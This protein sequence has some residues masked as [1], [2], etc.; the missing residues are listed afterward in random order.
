MGPQFNGPTQLTVVDGVATSVGVSLVTSGDLNVQ[1]LTAT[2][3]AKTGILSASGDNVTGSG[4]QS[5]LITGTVQQ[6]NAALATLTDTT[7]QADTVNITASDSSGNVTNTSIGVTPTSTPP[8][9]GISDALFYAILSMDAYN[10]QTDGKLS[11]GDPGGAGTSLGGATFRNFLQD[12]GSGGFFGVTWIYG[13]QTVIAYRGSTNPLNIITALTVAAGS[14]DAADEQAALQLYEDDK[15]G[16]LSFNPNIILTGH[17]LGGALAGWVAGNTGASSFDYDTTGYSVALQ[18]EYTDEYQA[19]KAGLGLLPTPPNFKTQQG[20]NLVGDVAANTRS[21]H[22]VSTPV[23][24]YAGTQDHLTLQ[25][26][27]TRHS[28]A[29]LVIYMY[30]AGDGI[31]NS[32]GS[33]IGPNLFS[34][35][36]NNAVAAAIGISASDIMDNEI[37]YSALQSGGTPF[38][39]T[40]IASLFH[41]ADALGEFY[42][43]FNVDDTLDDSVIQNDLADIAVEYAGLLAETADI[44]RGDENVI[45][46]GEGN[47]YLEVNLSNKWDNKNL[48]AT[49]VNEASLIDPG[50]MGTSGRIPSRRA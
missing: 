22:D 1:A 35:L 45:S 6:V 34:A 9:G 38:W 15:G 19:Y 49:V 5:L 37:A 8:A 30:A 41:D 47:Q 36:T 48:S 12:P 33:N 2:V 31:W 42:S 32:V 11:L 27:I 43:P 17:S 13:A 4:S 23:Q 24:T 10:R 25:E 20:Y 28:A 39:T 16:S 46:Y 7:T 29:L 14:T 3:T 18:N 26:Q 50:R 44:T 21:G 40:G